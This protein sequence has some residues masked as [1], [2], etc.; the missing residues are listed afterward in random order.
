MVGLLI[1]LSVIAIAGTLGLAAALRRARDEVGPTI[2]AF[3][4]FRR[5]LA[6]SLVGLRDDAGATATRLDAGWVGG[7]AGRGGPELTGR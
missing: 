5:A 6:P 3:D 4:E 2:T 1:I 7:L